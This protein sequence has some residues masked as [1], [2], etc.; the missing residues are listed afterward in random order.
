MNACRS[1]LVLVVP[2]GHADHVLF[3]TL[4]SKNYD[5]KELRCITVKVPNGCVL[6]LDALTSK[7]NPA[8]THLF[9]EGPMPPSVIHVDHLLDQGRQ[10]VKHAKVAGPI[11]PI[12]QSYPNLR[13]LDFQG[14]S[15]D[16]DWSSLDVASQ[17]INLKLWSYE[18][19]NRPLLLPPDCALDLYGLVSWYQS[20]SHLTCRYL[21]HA[22]SKCCKPL[23]WSIGYHDPVHKS[24]LQS[25]ILQQMLNNG[26]T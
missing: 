13:V 17:L 24:L 7:P 6:M 11:L 8:V 18:N 15:Y 21:Q 23:V 4:F 3:S 1:E 12:L 5:E 20:D 19:I 25:I 14:L 26:T 9:I 22:L 2:M 10:H 16:V